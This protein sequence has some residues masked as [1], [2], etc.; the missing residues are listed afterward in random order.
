MS[1]NI[2]SGSLA[3]QLAAE[4]LV[5]AGY[6]I[7]HRNWHFIH[8]EIDIV[9]EK[10]NTLIIVEVKSRPDRDITADEL[11]S[12]KKLR[13]IVDAAQAYIEQYEIE[14]EVQFD[15]IV[16]TFKEGGV[17]IEHI[18]NAFIPGINW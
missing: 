2:E 13:N 1:G 4:Y 3:E 7:I 17:H 11:L 5:E 15:L 12:Y 16:I 9:A 8:K 6:G 14:K 18:E 10:N